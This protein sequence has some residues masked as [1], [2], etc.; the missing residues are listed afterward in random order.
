[1]N[2][3]TTLLFAIMA[4]VAGC[5]TIPPITV[6]NPPVVITPTT[7]TTI[8]PQQGC[9]CDLSLPLA[10][11]AGYTEASV[12]A[13]ANSEECGTEAELKIIAR[14][15]VWRPD[16]GKYWTLSSLVRDNISRNADGTPNIKCFTRNGQRMH[17]RGYSQIEPQANCYAAQM[18][19]KP[20]KYIFIDCRNIK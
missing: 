14:A 18:D 20:A 17:I 1:M 15:M 7:T 9:G 2:R 3:I 13:N 11:P 19:S 16:D 5:I 8:P 12:A 4:I 10:N 6:S